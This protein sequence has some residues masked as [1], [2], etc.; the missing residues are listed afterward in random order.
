MARGL[1]TLKRVPMA[2]GTKQIAPRSKKMARL[3]GGD[4]GRAVFVALTLKVEPNCQIGWEGC[5]GRSEDVHESILR[6]RGGAIVPGAFAEAQGQR[7]FAICRACHNYTHAHRPAAEAWGLLDPRNA[8]QI[9]EA[10]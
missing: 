8:T 7:F 4:L 9:K 5:T 3:Y 10:P 2:R 6:S 1:A